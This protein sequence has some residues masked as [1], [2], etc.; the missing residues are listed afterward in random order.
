MSEARRSATLRFATFLAPSMEPVYRDVARE[1]GEAM[2]CATTLRTGRD[3]KELEREDIDVSFVCSPVYLWL[4][5]RQEPLAEAVAAPVLAD[6]GSGG[7]P[8]S[9]SDVI[10]A[11][12]SDARSFGDLRGR[13]FAYN[14][15]WSHSG[16]G[17]VRVR[18]AEM[19]A[20]E[21]FFG[22]VVEAGHHRRSMRMVGEGEV[23]AAAIDTQV[24][25][26]ERR[27]HREVT[28]RI[29]VIDRLGPYPVQPVAASTRLEPSIRAELRS[30]FADLHTH[31]GVRE[32]LTFGL[33]DRFVPV[34]DAD[35]DVTRSM[36][37][38][39]TASGL[40]GFGPDHLSD[41]GTPA[42]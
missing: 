28:Q 12:Q 13:S 39:V 29:R 24:L 35:Y 22:R 6:P 20:T 4:A 33:V 40:H 37:R 10:V 16:Y 32:A 15:P 21:G 14:E 41:P 25:A 38:A 2:G 42:P 17:C 27:E 7:K 23:E 3:L 1:V 30:V 18:L 26:I 31:P 9:H 19:G 8:V 36:Q 34:T 11:A 5:D